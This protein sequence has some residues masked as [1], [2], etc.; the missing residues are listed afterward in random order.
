MTLDTDDKPAA[1]AQV[2]KLRKAKQLSVYE[3]AIKN[4]AGVSQ[5]HWS[6]IESGKKV[7]SWEV[8]FLMLKSLGCNISIIVK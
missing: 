4:D 3:L 6:D 5:P 8:L 2:I 7:P 1:V